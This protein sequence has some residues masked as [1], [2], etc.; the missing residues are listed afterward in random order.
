MMVSC[1]ACTFS[2]LKREKGCKVK[3]PLLL[4]VFDGACSF[5]L[6][7]M[8]CSAGVLPGAHSLVW[9]M[10]AR[11]FISPLLWLLPGCKWCWSPR[12]VCIAVG[13]QTGQVSSQTVHVTTIKQLNGQCATKGQEFS[14]HEIIGKGGQG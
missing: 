13:K 9:E 3:V 14:S 7:A 5:V 2:Y 11:R 10:K 6:R 1:W 8:V 12:A 4:Q